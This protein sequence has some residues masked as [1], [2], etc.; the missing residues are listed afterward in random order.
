[1]STFYDYWEH[2]LDTEIVEETHGG[3]CAATAVPVP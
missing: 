1:M 3:Y 2:S